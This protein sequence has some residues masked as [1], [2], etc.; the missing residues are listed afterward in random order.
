MLTQT[1][2]AGCSTGWD[3]WEP[4]KFTA[5]TTLQCVQFLL[6][7]TPHHEFLKGGS[8]LE[9]AA[10]VSVEAIQVVERAGGEWNW[11]ALKAAAKA[12]CPDRLRYSLHRF[13]PA[14]SRH[15]YW[16]MSATIESNSTECMRIVYESGY[17]GGQDSMGFHPVEMALRK[18]SLEC[19]E[20]AAGWGGLPEELNIDMCE[21]AQRGVGYLRAAHGLGKQL[22]EMTAPAAAFAAQLEALRYARES[23]AV[24]DVR[25]LA[26]AVRGGALQCL[27]YAHA[28]GCTYSVS[29]FVMSDIRKSWGVE[30][31]AAHSPDYDL[32]VP[33]PSLPVL[34]YVCENLD[35][36][37]ASEVV[38]TTASALSEEL[39][40]RQVAGSHD[41]SPHATILYDWQLALYACSKIDPG[42]VPQPL[43]EAIEWRQSRAAALEDLFWRAG[44]LAEANAFHAAAPMWAAMSRL[45]L[46]LI[47]DIAFKA[48]LVLF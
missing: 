37:F 39:L 16:L 4:P 13:R 21:M 46:D 30:V 25:T 27:K 11:H 24:W 12:G 10:E 40:S 47:R 6:D 48:H 15:W 22:H 14:S 45:P 1:A 19:V 9:G 43:A 38:K 8:C 34:K 32:Q 28:H 17:L 44:E 26:A 29:H 36:R 41:D 35:A 20:E 3:D 33:A 18:A 2:G 31:R 7:R 5:K 23:G 42:E